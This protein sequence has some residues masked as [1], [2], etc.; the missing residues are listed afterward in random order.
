MRG[1]G[2]GY[3]LVLIFSLI[4]VFFCQGL[5]YPMTDSSLRTGMG[6]SHENKDTNAKRLKV[7]NTVV[8]VV[9]TMKKDRFTSAV[10]K[11]RK[12]ETEDISIELKDLENNLGRFSGL[13]SKYGIEV[14]IYEGWR[15]LITWKESENEDLKCI[16]IDNTGK[17]IPSNEIEAKQMEFLESTGLFERA[18]LGKKRGYEADFH[19]INARIISEAIREFETVLRSFLD[20][21][22]IS[23]FVLLTSHFIT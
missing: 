4:M 16:A 18:I 15:I 20:N 19:M 21:Y 22:D 11:M 1:I 13:L 8:S 23:L 17:I 5:S 3:S 9:R 7:V 6:F 2:K 12:D 10:E 14:A